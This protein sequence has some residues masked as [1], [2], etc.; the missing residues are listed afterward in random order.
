MTVF[1]DVQDHGLSITAGR[2]RVKVEGRG[3]A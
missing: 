3:C 1:D 2:G